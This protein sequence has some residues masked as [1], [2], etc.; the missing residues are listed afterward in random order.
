MTETWSPAKRWRREGTDRLCGLSIPQE[1]EQLWT[2]GY[3]T[4]AQALNESFWESDLRQ[5]LYNNFLLDM[6]KEINLIIRIS[7]PSE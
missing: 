1:V 7:K 2:F 5:I 6:A 4:Q 3:I